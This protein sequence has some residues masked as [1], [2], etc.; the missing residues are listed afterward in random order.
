MDETTIAEVISEMMKIGPRPIDADDETLKNYHHHA[1]IVFAKIV[2]LSSGKVQRE[3]KETRD[4]H[5]RQF[6][7]IGHG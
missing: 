3:Y 4:F 7:S 6:H 2:R 5:L 1:Y